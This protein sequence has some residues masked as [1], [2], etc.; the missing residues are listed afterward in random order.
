MMVERIQQSIRGCK[1][2]IKSVGSGTDMDQLK[3]GISLDAIEG[4]D[5]QG[6]RIMFNYQYSPLNCNILTLEEGFD[7]PTSVLTDFKDWITSKR[8]RDGNEEYKLPLV[9]VNICTNKEP[10]EVAA[11]GP[12]VAALIERFPLQYRSAW[13]TYTAAD[14]QELFNAPEPQ[15]CE[16]EWS[17]ILVLQAKAEQVVFPNSVKKILSEMLQKA[18]EKG[19]KISPRTANLAVAIIRAACVI[20]GRS[21]VEKS[22]IVAI[23]YLPGCQDLAATIEAEIDNAHKRSVAEEEL[24]TIES[25][26][27]SLKAEGHEAT[28]PIKVLQTVK[29]LRSLSDQLS[30][31]GVPDTLVERRNKLREAV[32]AQIPVLQK[33]AED[34]TR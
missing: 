9:S 7:L 22:D 34:V 29:G 20:H 1:W 2:N 8:F 32:D 26:F 27:T 30:G 17:E 12:E 10:G 23:K 33:R 18:G 25:R 19:E 14:Y 4:A 6:R 15:D 11:K 24:T 13:E 21:E 28:A 3:G 16:I 5:G 31:L